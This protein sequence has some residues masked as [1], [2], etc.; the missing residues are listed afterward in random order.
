[1]ASKIDQL[2]KKIDNI[3]EKFNHRLDFI[4]K[5][6]QYLENNISTTVKEVII[7]ELVSKN[8]ELDT[9]VI[10]HS[11]EQNSSNGDFLLIKKFYFEKDKNSHTIQLGSDELLKYWYNNSWNYDEKYL[12]DILIKNIRLHYLLVNTFDNYNNNMEQFMKNQEYIMELSDTTA[13]YQENL[14]KNIKNYLIS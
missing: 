5:R 8:F 13:K 7:E 1:M 6:L 10:K 14:L 11:L 4:E 12:L 3:V 9:K 2:N